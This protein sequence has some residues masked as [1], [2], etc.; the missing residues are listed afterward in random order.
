MVHHVVA[1]IATGIGL[2]TD[3]YMLGATNFVEHYAHDFHATDAQKDFVKAAMYGGAI[4]GMIVMG[5]LSDII[6]RRAGLIL[7]SLITLCGAL[8]SMF[9]WCENALI[10]ARIITGIGMGG[11]YPLASSH[12]A[13][14]SESTNDGAKN[15]ALLY[16]FGS[17]GGQALCPLVT[18]IMD[19]AGVPDEMLW[20]GIFAVG[21]VLSLLGL[22]LRIVATK[23]SQKFKASREDSK[24]SNQSTRSLLRP[25]WRPL[26][27]TAGAWFLYDV[28]EYGLKQNDAAIFDANHDGDYSQSV[29]AV[30]CTRMLVIPSL[31]VAPW[32]LTKIS[33]RK[34]QVV[35]F[36]GC[37]LCNLGLALGYGPLK[38]I[39]ILFIGLYIVQLSFQSLPGVTTMAISAEIFPSMVRGTG[40]GISAAFGKLGATIGSYAFSELKNLGLIATIFWVVVITSFLAILLT[41]Y[42]IPYY[43]GSTLDAADA[44]AREG[45]MEEAVRVLFAGPRNLEVDAKS[46]YAK[47]EV[48]SDEES[49]SSVQKVEE[50][51]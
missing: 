30:F 5:P 49:G 15:V 33:S 39:S 26:F 38:E 28:V 17:G 10:V 36:L 48:T 16:L 42:A 8:L 24:A 29:L 34:V 7:C 20:R 9:A 18:Y 43:N 2:L 13:E 3:K 22:G 32:L 44:L 46:K 35:G 11:E 19:V 21:S 25:Y 23:D 14:S 1:A 47:D 12:S 45:Q 31:I 37:A 4:L 6:G 50:V 40:A 41:F 27:G 51:Q